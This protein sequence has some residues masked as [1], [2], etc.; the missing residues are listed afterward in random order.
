MEI[1]VSSIE[2][3]PFTY[4]VGSPYNLLLGDIFQPMKLDK[5]IEEEKNEQIHSTVSL[6]QTKN[7]NWG[8]FF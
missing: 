6:K 2:Y 4:F 3:L 5:K 7:M 1:L 8:S